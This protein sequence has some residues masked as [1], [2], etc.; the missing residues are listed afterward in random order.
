MDFWEENVGR[1][2]KKMF[3][4]PN[5]RQLIY[6]TAC[7]DHAVFQMEAYLASHVPK[8]ALITL[9]RAVRAMWDFLSGEKLR[10]SQIRAIINELQEINPGED[11]P[12]LAPGWGDILDGAVS[13]CEMLKGGDPSEWLVNCISYAY[14]AVMKMAIKLEA[15]QKIT[16]ASVSYR[17]EMNS[18]LC[19][20]EV[21]FQI[22]CLDAVESSRGIESTLFPSYKIQ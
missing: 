5:K 11:D 20:A 9:N 3:K 1:R 4:L 8:K 14:Q 7:V 16:T 21:Q 10:P 13:A 15:T 19:Q 12:I 18:P 6:A 17:F 22:E 2:E